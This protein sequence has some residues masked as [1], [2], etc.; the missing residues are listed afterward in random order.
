MA[1][2][3]VVSLIISVLSATSVATVSRV[4]RQ[5]EFGT[6]SLSDFMVF[7]SNNLDADCQSALLVILG[8]LAS[9]PDAS[10][11][12][13]D[14]EHVESYDTLCAPSCGQKVVEYLGGTCESEELAEFGVAVCAQQPDLGPLCYDVAVEGL[15]DTM[16]VVEECYPYDDATPCPEPCQSALERVSTTLGCCVLNFYDGVFSESDH[17]SQLVNTTVWSWC[18]VD[19]PTEL[20]GSTLQLQ[21]DAAASLSSAALWP[22]IV[23]AILLQFMVGW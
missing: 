14:P 4:E 13:L 12:S 20:C 8:S 6:C 1:P 10:L 23:V 5:I 3:T 22:L 11:S 21:T 7:S 2:I 16:S 19:F 17:A 9:S 15:N 18:S